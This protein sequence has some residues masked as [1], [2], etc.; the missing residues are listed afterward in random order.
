M[1]ALDGALRRMRAA[2]LR[3]ERDS[4]RAILAAW[5][6]AWASLS[7]YV[8]AAI[9]QA[10][11]AQADTPAGATFAVAALPTV[12]AL[13]G[14]LPSILS[15]FGLVAGNEVADSTWEAV[16]KARP[17][18]NAATLA[19]LGTPPPGAAIPNLA[20][21]TA[22]FVPN[23]EAS[24]IAAT[25]ARL[26]PG[27][28]D[29]GA[30][31]IA[32]GVRAGKGARAI[33]RDVR[34]AANVAPVRALVVSRESINRGFRES[35]LATYRANRDI[36]TSYRWHCARSSRTCALCWAMDG[37]VFDIDRPFASHVCCRC[38]MLPITRD[39]P[40]Y[41]SPPLPESGREAFARLN[42]DEQRRILGVGKY[43]LFAD[44]LL[45]W[46]ALA[47]DTFSAVYGPGRRETPL[48][49]LRR[50]A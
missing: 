11:A 39:L 45:D 49:E 6:R 16:V 41:Q 46:D 8:Q 3:T 17:L 7:P 40:G 20:P 28:G 12:R 43:Q 2:A 33:A 27:I 30:Q 42:A 32:A 36:V 5:Q 22:L 25:I 29:A 35:A 31:A 23:V 26:A 4:Q 44:G 15:S 10:L 24:Q 18:A 38:T 19:A 34:L 13:T 50:T 48:R 1:T 14:A 47:T 37:K 9:A 21:G